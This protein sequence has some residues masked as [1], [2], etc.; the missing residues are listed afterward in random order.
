MNYVKT[1]ISMLKRHE[2]YRQF[3]YKDT[4]GV[5]TIGY[6]RNL[7]SRGISKE[8][9][10]YLLMNDASIADDFLEKAFCYY[11]DLDG[12]RRAVLID[13]LVNLG[14]PR[15]SKFKKM[16]EALQSHNYDEAAAEM[17]DSKWA[18]QV[19]QR[20]VTLSQVMITGEI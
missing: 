19:G 2:G 18:H 9:A 3:P 1:A 11:V 17:L 15:L 5:T 8:E 14:A 12:P 20:A 10:E 13:M 4:V 16:H 7:E 6:G